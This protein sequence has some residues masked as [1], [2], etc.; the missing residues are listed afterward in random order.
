MR[1]AIDVTSLPPRPAGAARYMCGLISGLAAVDSD[2]EY[3]VFAKQRDLERFGGLPPNFHLVEI[4]DLSRPLRLLW[5]QWA[6][7]RLASRYRLDVWHA[8][9]YLLPRGMRSTATVVT[10]HDMTFFLYPQ[11]HHRT[12]VPFFQ[13]AIR[14]AV[15]RADRIVAVSRTTRHDTLRLFPEA[16][17]R[18][19]HVYSGVQ[20]AFR[21]TV[22]SGRLVQTLGFAPEEPF[23]LFVGAFEKRKNLEVVLH[24]V[25]ALRHD[26]LPNLRVVLTGPR[27][28]GFESVRQTIEKLGLNEA[29]RFTGYVPDADLPALYSAADVFVFPSLYEGFGFPPLEAMACG[30]PTL[31]SDAPAVQELTANP[32]MQIAATDVE[33]WRRKLQRVFTDETFCR[34]LIQYGQA[35]VRTFDWHETARQMRA[36]Y[37]EAYA[38]KFPGRSTPRRSTVQEVSPLPEPPWNG[39]FQNLAPIEAAILRTVV[40][41]DLFDYPLRLEEIHR[42]LLGHAASL[43][44]VKQALAGAGLAPYLQQHAGHYFLRGKAATVSSRRIREQTS[45]E[46]LRRHRRLL[47]LVGRF[48]FVRGAAL[49]GAAAFRNCVARDDLDLFLIVHPRRTWLV[50]TAL[51]LLLKLL[52]K[53]RLLC[54]NYLYGKPN[55]TVAERDFFVAHQIAF[56]QPISGNGLFRAFLQENGWVR[57]YLPQAEIIEQAWARRFTVPPRSR[58]QRALEAVLGLRLFDALEAHAYRWYGAHIRRLT[59]HLPDSVRVEKDRIMLFTNDHKTRALE[60]FRKRLQEV[61]AQ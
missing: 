15:K 47:R 61:A 7:A 28:N 20:K 27:E 32:A 40:Y 25:H 58:L 29:V 11:L 43:E 55:L 19:R 37:E 1:I 33:G 52:R 46:L 42:G 56:L 21:P 60:R 22:P 14:Q 44:E 26:G 13:H 4:P 50:Y 9:H 17:G 10:F 53:R 24:A 59:R 49:S 18:I 5:Q 38:A 8:P 3:F 12:K 41:A 2:N 51:A 23:A 48:P 16:E 54:L 39:H 6:P 30:T 57:T 34:E 31:T 45:S 36:V 35:R